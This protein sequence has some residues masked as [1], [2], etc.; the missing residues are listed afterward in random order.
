MAAL[1]PLTTLPVLRFAQPW[2]PAAGG[3]SDWASAAV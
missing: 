1:R 3:Y 2:V